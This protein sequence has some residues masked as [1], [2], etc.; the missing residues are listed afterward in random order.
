[1]RFTECPYCK[2]IALPVE[3]GDCEE[4]GRTSLFNLGEDTQPKD[5]CAINQPVFP[6][7]AQVV[8]VLAQRTFLGPHWWSTGGKI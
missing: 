2:E 3:G 4:C 5:D 6:D 7:P 8:A 1:M